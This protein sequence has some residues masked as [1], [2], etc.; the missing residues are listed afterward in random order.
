M[1][2]E[3]RVRPAEAVPAPTEEVA[4]HDAPKKYV[5]KQVGVLTQAGVPMKPGMEILL[6]AEEYERFLGLGYIYATDEGEQAKADLSA[7]KAQRRMERQQQTA[8]RSNP[9]QS[10]EGTVEMAAATATEAP[11]PRAATGHSARERA[12]AQRNREGQ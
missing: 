11:A 4:D 12:E 10:G 6:T 2:E 1:A 8:A 7:A 9:Q 5:V 3:L